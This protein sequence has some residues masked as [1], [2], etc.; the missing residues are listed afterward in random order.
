MFKQILIIGIVLQ[1]YSS[2]RFQLLSEIWAKE[3]NLPAWVVCKLKIN[4]FNSTGPHI[5][6]SQENTILFVK[7][8]RIS[9]IYLND[10]LGR[11]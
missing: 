8:Y 4:P 10:L 5:Q 11:E 3:E 6:G 7:K 1:L 9:P 2:P